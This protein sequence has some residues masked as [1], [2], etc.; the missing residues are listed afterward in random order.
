[1]LAANIVIDILK[2][3]NDET[4]APAIYFLS[5]TTDSPCVH[6]LYISLSG[7]HSARHA[8]L[9]KAVLVLLPNSTFLS[10][11]N[12]FGNN[13]L[14]G[15]GSLNVYATWTC[16]NKF[17]ECWGTEL[18]I[19]SNICSSFWLITIFIVSSLTLS[20]SNTL[21]DLSINPAKNPSQKGLSECRN[22]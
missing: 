9:F 3:L 8:T 15:A 20:R 5:Y 4:I 17:I 7:L 6:A 19:L 16:S 10:L 11:D 13:F 12:C 1:M 2:E 18:P 22:W 21:P 14:S